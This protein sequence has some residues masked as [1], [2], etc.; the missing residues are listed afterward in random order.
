MEH[1]DRKLN[2]LQ[3]YDYSRNGLYFITICTKDRIPY[4]SEIHD[5]GN[6]ALGVPIVKLTEYGEIVNDNIK[7]INEIYRYVSV[8]KYVI[9]P[10]HIHMILF[11]SDFEDRFVNCG[12]PRAAFPT[13]SVSQ[14]INGLKSISTKQIGFSIWQKS[15]H[16][17]IIRNEKEFL[18]ICD[19]IDNNPINWVNDIYNQNYW[20]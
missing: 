20:R 13:K 1:S 6:A 11:V 14:I 17:H 5:V 8:T 16:D 9:M 19:Y 7:K 15:F 18:E 10:D 3:N 2:R 12:T 4:L